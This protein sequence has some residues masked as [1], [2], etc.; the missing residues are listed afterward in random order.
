MGAVYVGFQTSL[1]RKIAVK[2]FP[3]TNAALPFFR[4]RFRDEA[5]TV[6][7]LNH[8]D[9]APVFDMGETESCFFNDAV[10]CGEDLKNR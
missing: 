7:V 3:K 9:I 4:L 10:D 1:K 8:P 5:E 2:I 6:A